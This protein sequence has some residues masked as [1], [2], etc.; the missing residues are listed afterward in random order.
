MEIAE[1]EDWGMCGAGLESMCDMDEVV[2]R[3]VSGRLNMNPLVFYSFLLLVPSIALA[4]GDAESATGAGRPFSASDVAISNDNSRTSREGSR[5]ENDTLCDDN[6]R[7]QRIDGP[8]GGFK[9]FFYHPISNKIRAVVTNDV[10]TVFTYNKAGDMSRIFNTH[11]QLITLDYDKHG[12]ISRMIE[13]NHTEHI[14][15]E[16]TFKYD[17]KRRPVKIRMVG[18]GEIR[19][20]YDQYGEILNVESKQGAATAQGVMKAF[21][22][23]LK[24]V[25]VGRTSLSR[26]P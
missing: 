21:Q 9:E 2:G 12:K 10:S 11:G 1:N 23:L 15:R 8:G 3:T 18:K 26:S 16:L 20:Q 5:I 7:V 22:V 25:Q 14:R 6:G 19:V 24:A 4:E 17:A 13:T